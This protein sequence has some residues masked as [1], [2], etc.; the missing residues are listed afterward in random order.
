MQTKKQRLIVQIVTVIFVF[1]LL[2][3]PLYHAQAQLVVTDPIT[4]QATTIKNI[5]DFITKLLVGVAGVAVI[6]AADYFAQ[7]LAYDAAVALA[8]GGKGEMPLFSTKGWGDYFKDA[9][10][11][12][13]GEF[14]GTLSEGFEDLDLCNPGPA[15]LRVRIQTGLVDPYIPVGEGPEP[16]CTWNEISENWDDFTEE[17]TTG[18]VL[19]RTGVMFESGQSPLAVTLEAGKK[20]SYQVYEAKQLSEL[21]RQEGEGFFAKTGIIS[22]EVQTPAQVI[23]EEGK[24]IATEG[25][26]AQRSNVQAMGQALS[27]GA[28]QIL[29]S[30][31]GTFVNTLA[32]TLLE[33]VFN[34]GLLSLADLQKK[35]GSSSL[36]N[37]EFSLVGTREVAQEIYSDFI[38]PPIK[39]TD[40]YDLITEFSVCPAQ[41]AGP[42]NCVVDQSFA[43]AIRREA[44]GSPVNVSQAIDEGLL[45]GDWPLISSYD[46]ARNADVYCHTYGYCYSNLVKL[47]EARI[48]PVG[49]EVAAQ[50]SGVVTGQATL[51]EVM[52]GFYDCGTDSD[53]N[54][55]AD[56]DHP[57]CHLIDPNWILKYPLTQCRASVYGPTLLTSENSLRSETCVD[58]PTCIAVDDDGNCVGGWGYCTREKNSWH[59]DGDSCPATFESCL[60]FENSDG[61][62]N[63]Y[64]LNTVNYSVCNSDNAG[65]RWYSRA[66]AGDDWSASVVYDEENYS[67]VATDNAIYLDKDVRECSQADAGCTE[68]IRSSE[69][70][71]TLNLLANSSFET[72]SASDP[73]FPDKWEEAAPGTGIFTYDTTGDNAFIGQAAIMPGPVGATQNVVLNPSRFYTFSVFAMNTDGATFDAGV[74]VRDSSGIPVDLSA[75]YMS[76]VNCSRSGTSTILLDNITPPEIFA[77]YY[78]TFTTPPASVSPGGYFIGEFEITASGSLSGDVWI[79]GV[80]LEESE[81]PTGFHE[82]IATGGERT[83]LRKPPASLGC[84]GADTDAEECDNYLRVCSPLDVGCKQYFPDEGGPSLSGITT[85][86]DLCPAQCVGYETFRE[87]PTQWAST[88]KFPMF[89][90]PDTGEQCVASEVGCDEFTNLDAPEVGGESTSYFTEI[91]S[92]Q[93]PADDS[94]TFYTWEGSDTTGFQLKTWT[95]KGSNTDN[96]PCTT[97]APEGSCDDPAIGTPEYMERDC[98]DVFEI[99]ADCREFFD[100]AGDVFYRY[101]SDTVISTEQCYRYRKTNNTGQTDCESS[102]GRWTD[103]NE[104]IYMGYPAESQLCS[105]SASGCRAYTGATSRNVEEEFYDNFEGV[106]SEWTGGTL[107]TESV[108]LDGHSLKVLSGDTAGKAW[109]IQEG[110]TYIMNFWAKGRGNITVAVDGTSLGGV[111]LNAEWNQYEV[112]PILIEETL[113]SSPTITLAGFTEDSYIDNITLERVSDHIY[114]IKNSWYTPLVCDMNNQGVYLPQAQLG[115]EAYSDV[116]NNTHYIKSFARLCSD[117]AVGCEGFIDTQNS[118]TSESAIYNSG[119]LAEILVP[120]DTV[121]Y[122]VYDEAFSCGEDVKGCEA[123]GKPVISQ[124]GRS[125]VDWEDV[126]LVNYPDEYSETLCQAEEAFCDEFTAETGSYYF[127]EP[128]NKSCEFKEKVTLAGVEYNGWFVSGTSTPCYPTYLGG[129]NIYG[130]WRNGDTNYDAWYGVCPDQY[131]LCTKYIDPSDTSDNYSQGEEY[132]YLNND[133]IDQTCASVSKGEGCALFDNA[134]NPTKNY[135]SWA[136]YLTSEDVNFE[137]VAPIDCRTSDS[138]YC[139]NKCNYTFI[140]SGGIDEI[141]GHSCRSDIDCQEYS[142]A[143]I[144]TCEDISTAGQRCRKYQDGLDAYEWAGSCSETSDCPVDWECADVERTLKQNDTNTIVKVRRDR[145]CG[146]WL[147]C[148]SSVSVWDDEAFKYKNVCTNLGLCDE[149]AQVGDSGECI[150]FI[151]SDYTGDILSEDIYTK[152]DVSWDGMDYSGFAVPNYYSVDEIQPVDLSTLTDSE[153]PELRLAYVDGTCSANYQECGD[154]NSL[155]NRGVCVPGT[156]CVYSINGE[157]LPT[158]GNAKDFYNLLNNKENLFRLVGPTC[159]AYPEETSPFPSR[160]GDWV[161]GRLTTINSKFKM[162]NVCEEAVW[163]DLDGD[164]ERDAAEL[165]YQDC[166]CSYEKATYGNGASTKFYSIGEANIPKGIC[167]NGPR[168]GLDCI[169]GVEYDDNQAGDSAYNIQTCG[170]IRQGGS[171]QSLERTDTFVGW[172]GQCLERDLRINLNG[173]PEENACSMWYPSY[174]LS[175]G[176]DI[177][178]IYPSAGYNPSNTGRYWCLLGKGLRTPMG[179]SSLGEDYEVQTRDQAKMINIGADSNKEYK[180]AFWAADATEK[181]YK[182]DIVAIEMKPHGANAGDWPNGRN[183]HT[184]DFYKDG[185]HILSR[186]NEENIDFGFTVWQVNWNLPEDLEIPSEAPPVF[187]DSNYAYSYEEDTSGRPSNTCDNDYNTDNYFAIRAVFK[188]DGEFKGFWT[189]GC[190][191]SSSQGWVKFDVVFHMADPCLVVAQAVDNEGNSKAYTD[192]LYQTSN[193]PLS[194]G[195]EYYYSQPFAPFGSAQSIEEPLTPLTEGIIVEPWMIGDGLG[196]ESHIGSPDLSLLPEKFNLAGSSFG[197]LGTCSDEA[198]G[199]MNYQ[200]NITRPLGNL[201]DLFAKVYNLY[202]W[203]PGHTELQCQPSTGWTL[204]TGRYYIPCGEEGDVCE[205]GTGTCSTSYACTS[206]PLKGERNC[207][208]LSGFCTGE[209]ATCEEITDD[210][211]GVTAYLCQN[212]LR[213]EELCSGISAPPSGSYAIKGSSTTIT[214]PSV[215]DEIG[216]DFCKTVGSCIDWVSGTEE[217]YK[218]YGGVNHDKPCNSQSDC[219]FSAVDNVSCDNGLCAGGVYSSLGYKTACADLTQCLVSASSCAAEDANRCNGGILD[220]AICGGE[221][222]N[223]CGVTFTCTASETSNSVRGFISKGC[224]ANKSFPCLS[225]GDCDEG[226]R[227]LPLDSSYYDF[228]ADIGSDNAGDVGN[229]PTIAAIDFSKC[230]QVTGT[231]RTA[232]VDAFDINNWYYGVVTGQDQLKTSLRFYAWADHDQMPIVSRTIDWGDSSPLDRTTVSKYKNQKPYCGEEVFECNNYEGLTCKNNSDC[233]GGTGACQP[234]TTPHFGNDPDACS[235]GYFQFEH[236]YICDGSEDLPTCGFDPTPG[237]NYGLVPDGGC[238]TDNACFFRPRVQVLDN[239]GWCNGNCFGADG[240]Y[241]GTLNQCDIALTET[242][243]DLDPWTE[244]DGYIK[245]NK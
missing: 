181:Y 236:T 172:E 235:Q 73:G 135:D 214:V 213:G 207:G 37:P 171:C 50:K 74:T 89:F 93:L 33:R 149:Y 53:G 198:Y 180:E 164:N 160:I 174:I 114:L 200:G 29:A 87:E 192:R 125:V 228:G 176:Q 175:G 85:E 242:I 186:Q 204:G 15:G 168:A 220:G 166:E 25:D 121:S 215:D 191:D 193:Y 178:N 146:E 109:D 69:A 144:K 11:N 8:T 27:A 21:E 201:M 217:G 227:C 57:W 142:A 97:L 163:R 32:G 222:G 118:A 231:C 113:P 7:K 67:L 30:A 210:E 62:Q 152:R 48:I 115:C 211:T 49:W 203:F 58:S 46:R 17:F 206:G 128:G 208:G 22:G 34:K 161:D 237:S 243:S 83:Y 232:Q 38:T 141:Y 20:L 224:E 154:V 239:W 205:G 6:N 9:S 133:R 1:N 212:S 190:D 39:E 111:S 71:I 63:S 219:D 18:E 110:E 157:S 107:S 92:C 194:V 70:G 145:E 100:T 47:R 223:Y 136:T 36:I 105:E 77:R 42:N 188:P 117:D 147:A 218:C 120:A 238:K 5:K 165:T 68:F 94:V 167:L 233:P 23:A 139:N 112:G 52:E 41:F 140:G 189:A 124:D 134:S 182:D 82:G 173:D 130:I 90:I 66:P 16:K 148:Q 132:Y 79:D 80:Q 137:G 84:T 216:E 162:A 229:P 116:E 245:I 35:K 72:P 122:Y 59:F 75:Y 187:I 76:G 102:G 234:T 153:T 156:G 159:R 13:V 184:E 55:V 95:L 108:L 99:D 4:G 138:P 185:G 26:E 195:S 199:D 158:A 2:L 24:Q 12:M 104:C 196:D 61:N 86:E 225:D 177:Y 106:S 60:T 10:L 241:S 202:A 51:R 129:G 151:E 45:R 43:T 3:I 127:K 96:G 244:F 56:S 44:T 81:S 183:G 226:E 179:D 65:C 14:V 88:A 143:S 19:S 131:N 98:S 197:C 170:S 78:C 54:A 221:Y 103:T 31:L 155:G 230:D 240:C 126:F 209:G 28:T 91:R 101:Y 119:S 150:N 40:V 64:L 169:P 123:M